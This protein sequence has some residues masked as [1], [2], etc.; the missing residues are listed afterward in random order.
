MISGGLYSC[1]SAPPALEARS[2]LLL[3]PPPLIVYSRGDMGAGDPKY[4]RRA[5]AVGTNTL[6]AIAVDLDMDDDVVDVDV[7][8][9]SG[10]HPPIHASCAKRMLH[11]AE[12]IQ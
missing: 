7:V 10:K 1:C 9:F 5:A 6:E 12:N 8:S 4:K 11:P 2:V 3:V